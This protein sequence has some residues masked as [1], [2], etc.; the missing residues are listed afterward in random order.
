MIDSKYK[1]KLFPLRL[2]VTNK[3]RETILLYICYD[4]RIFLKAT[5]C[6]LIHED[7]KLSDYI[8]NSH[9]QD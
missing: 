9:K 5:N 8:L 2:I 6:V 3:V 4:L 7:K 1:V